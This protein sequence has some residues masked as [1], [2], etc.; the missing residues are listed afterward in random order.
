[1]KIVDSNIII[2]AAKEYPSLRVYLNK[3][4]THISEI[5]KLEVLGYPNLKQ[6]DRL[7]FEAVFATANIIPVDSDNKCM[8]CNYCCVCVT[9]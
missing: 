9:L 8:R 4:D 6:A 2:Y 5:S 3:K 7:Y 1:M